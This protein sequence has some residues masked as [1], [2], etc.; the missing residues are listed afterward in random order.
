MITCLGKFTVRVS[1]VKIYQCCVCTS[2]TFGFR[3]GMR[4]KI[5]SVYDHGL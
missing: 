5:V 2:S 3:D 1:V 4:D